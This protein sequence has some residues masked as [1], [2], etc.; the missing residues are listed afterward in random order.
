MILYIYAHN[1][2]LWLLLYTNSTSQTCCT[3]Q[4]NPPTHM[5]MYHAL[6]ALM[7]IMVACTVEG[8]CMY[9][10]QLGRDS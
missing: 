7:R 9:Y 2:V 6:A 1:A 8:V 4:M 10:D 5:Q 3:W